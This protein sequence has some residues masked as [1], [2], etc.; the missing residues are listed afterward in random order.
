[1][2]KGAAGRFGFFWLKKEGVLLQKTAGAAQTQSWGSRSQAGPA[3]RGAARLAPNP[4]SSHKPLLSE[5]ESWSPQPSSKKYKVQG[6]VSD[7]LP[8]ASAPQI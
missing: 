7:P 3:G 6:G 2:R 1:M 5:K 8:T 4:T